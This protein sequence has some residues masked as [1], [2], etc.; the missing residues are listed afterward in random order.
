[1]DSLKKNISV[2]IYVESRYKV[3]RKRMKRTVSNFLESQGIKGPAEV[4]VAVVGDRK[5]RALNKK[6]RGLDKTTNV[7]SFSLVE[8][9]ATVL[10]DDV[11]QLGDIVISFPQVIR[12][13][14]KEEKMVDDKIDELLVH[15]TLHLMGV[16][17]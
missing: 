16:H 15:S 3:N 10:P 5:M 2:L 6:H 13:A 4:S 8:G 9:S 12:E 17:H 14:S 7:L 1:M 11:L